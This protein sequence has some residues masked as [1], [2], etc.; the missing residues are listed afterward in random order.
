MQRTVLL[1]T[2][3]LTAAAAIAGD[4][5]HAGL[6]DPSKATD[7]APSEFRVK[8]ETSKGSFTIK[9][10]R[11]WAPKGAD[12]FYNL[13][14]IGYFKDIAFYRVIEGFIVQFGFHGDPK[15]NKRWTNNRFKDDPV[16]QSNTA[17]RISFAMGGP[18]TRSTQFFINTVDNKNLDPMGFSPFGELEGA[19]LEVIKKLYSGY[20]ECAPYG[21]GPHQGRASEGGNAYFKKG[22]PKLD[23]ILSATLLPPENKE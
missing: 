14:K 18:N 7:Q 5:P 17:G 8:V 21:P 23:Y 22:F 13:V 2:L 16:T 1:F 6:L 12:R 3:F 20:G 19:G 15:V 10:H 9:V 4:E 11:D